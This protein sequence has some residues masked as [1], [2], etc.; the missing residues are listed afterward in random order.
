MI[1]YKLQRCPLCGRIF[2][3]LAKGH[4]CKEFNACECMFCWYQNRSFV[5]YKKDG[6]YKTHSKNGSSEACE[7]FLDKKDFLITLLCH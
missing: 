5:V 4:Y 6:I 1:K 7:I 3:C 2:K